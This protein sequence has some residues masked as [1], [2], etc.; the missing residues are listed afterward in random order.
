MKCN[1][2]IANSKCHK[3]YQIYRRGS[4]GGGWVSIR[5][6]KKLN[7]LP[8]FF[9]LFFLLLIS[10]FKLLYD[11][12]SCCAIYEHNFS[13]LNKTRITT[14]IKAKPW[15]QTYRV[16]KLKLNINSKLQKMYK[17]CCHKIQDIL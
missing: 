10:R 2:K 8:H 17:T 3:I 14:F 9:F 5:F 1:R 11:L 6:Y 15:N 13:C 4:E 16:P 7:S 12:L